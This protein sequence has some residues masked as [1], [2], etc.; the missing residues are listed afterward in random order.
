MPAREDQTQNE[1]LNAL[2]WQ[3]VPKD[4]FV[5]R[6]AIEFGLYDAIAHF[7][8]GAKIVLI[9]YKALGISPG[10]HTEAGCEALDRERLYKAAYKEKEANKKRRKVLRGQKKRKEDKKK[11]SGGVTYGA[12]QF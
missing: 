12:G 3:R 9:L 8:N 5:S 1:S 10:K 11:D 7:K 6:D 2:V 4:V